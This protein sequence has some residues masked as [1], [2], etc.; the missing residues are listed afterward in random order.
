MHPEIVRDYPGACPICGMA[1]EPRTPA[2]EEGPNVELVDMSRRFWVAAVLAAPVFILAMSDMLPG[3][4]L[5]FLDMKV[6]NC[7]QLVLSTPVVWWCGWPFFQRAWISVV[8]RSPNMFTLIALGV[9]AAF[10]YSLAATLVPDSFPDEMRTVHGA[11]PA[12]FDTAAVVTVLVLLGQVLE[13]RARSQTSGA[14]R[15]IDT[16]PTTARVVHPD[17]KEEDIATRPR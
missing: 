17:G 10:V 15:K 16:P 8:Q 14:I 6:A 4:L 3:N 7:L 2:V 11:V 13:I 9:G 1:L 5:H 12:Y